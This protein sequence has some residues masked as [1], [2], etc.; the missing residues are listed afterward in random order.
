MIV[1]RAISLFI[2]VSLCVAGFGINAAAEEEAQPMG[3]WEWIDRF[4]TN[5]AINQRMKRFGMFDNR[6]EICD[7]AHAFLTAAQQKDIAAM[8]ELFAPNAI[9]EVGDEQLDEM[10]GEFMNY[11]QADSFTLEAPIGPICGQHFNGGKKSRELRG[12]VEMT[13]DKSEY[14]IAIKCVPIDDWNED[15]IGIWSVYIIERSKDTDL[16]S[17]YIGDKKYRTG[18]YTDVPRPE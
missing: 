15:N 14:R 17:I 13:S 6:Q 18:V 1:K 7:Y 8:K 5:Y 16:E 3:I 4:L 12:P 11:F 9:S 2:A 10:M